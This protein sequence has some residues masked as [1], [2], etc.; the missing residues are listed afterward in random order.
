MGKSQLSV[1]GPAFWSLL[2]RR[3]HQPPAA[4]CSCGGCSG[5]WPEEEVG[6]GKAQGL[7]L[8]PFGGVPHAELRPRKQTRGS[9]RSGW[10]ASFVAPLCLLCTRKTPWHQL[11][12]S[13]CLGC[14]LV[15]RSVPL[16]NPQATFATVTSLNYNGLHTGCVCNTLHTK[17]CTRSNTS[18]FSPLLHGSRGSL[19]KHL[20][21]A[22]EAEGAALLMGRGGGEGDGWQNSTMALKEFTQRRRVSRPLTFHWPKQVI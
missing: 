1:W 15:P 3:S 14:P 4:S 21:S 16:Q 17:Y 8:G 13:V 18:V 19:R 5:E 2:G 11:C 10:S 12:A 20:H 6:K 7:E 22:V 9:P